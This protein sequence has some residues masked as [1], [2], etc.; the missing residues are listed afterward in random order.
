M[1]TPTL[2]LLAVAAVLFAANI[3]NLVRDLRR[4]SVQRAWARRRRINHRRRLRLLS[5]QRARVAATR[6]LWPDF[7]DIC[8]DRW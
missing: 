8:K 4:E 2:I 5:Q 1:L 6:V 7:D 3:R